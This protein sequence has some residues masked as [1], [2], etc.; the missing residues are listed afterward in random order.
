MKI[1]GWI[2]V[3]CKGKKNNEVIILLV[4]FFNEIYIDY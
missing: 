1:F 4:F 3:K 2:E